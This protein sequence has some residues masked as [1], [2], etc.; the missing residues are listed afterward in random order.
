MMKVEAYE[1]TMDWHSGPVG[2]LCQCDKLP[3]CPMMVT[4]MQDHQMQCLYD[5]CCV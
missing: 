2:L 4:L 1:A 5:W 3:S